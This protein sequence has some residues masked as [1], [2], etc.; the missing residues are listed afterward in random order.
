M[1]TESPL[2][3]QRLQELLIRTSRTFALAIPLLPEPL[4]RQVAVAYL[5]F[6]VAD[7]IEDGEN[8]TRQEKLDAFDRFA[9][10]LHGCTTGSYAMPIAWLPRQPCQNTDYMELVDAVG[11]VLCVTRSMPPAARETILDS[12]QQSIAGMRRFVA[13]GD[14]SG[15]VQLQTVAELR[16]Y[17]YFVAGLVGEMLTRLF[18]TEELGL[19]D[20]EPQLVEHARWFGEGLQLVN[21]LKDSRDD[22]SHGRRFIPLHQSRTEIFE[23]AEE[24]LSRAAR[25]VEILRAAGSS[26]GVIAFADL[27]RRL[28]DQTL[29]CVRSNGPGSKLP[30]SKVRSILEQTLG[31][32]RS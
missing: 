23:L 21:I 11:G 4:R 20:V 15:G 30:R 7:T 29:A 10:I 17:C 18:V 12:V 16:D 1:S 6:R 3:D 24:D 13:A 8:L 32:S 28:A 14:A 31:E 9:A 22:A 27:P 5:L 26:P 19:R 2:T 25:Y